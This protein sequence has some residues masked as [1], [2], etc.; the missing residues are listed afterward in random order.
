MD[1]GVEELTLLFL[2]VVDF[3]RWGDIDVDEF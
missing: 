1:S 3:T 2:A